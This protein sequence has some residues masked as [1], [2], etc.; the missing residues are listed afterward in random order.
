MYE[1]SSEHVAAA[2]ILIAGHEAQMVARML[3]TLPNDI[4]P[5]HTDITLMLDAF[6]EKYPARFVS[7]VCAFVFDEVMI[8]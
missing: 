7:Q 3:S 1:V 2:R 6:A 4:V 5:V 8:S